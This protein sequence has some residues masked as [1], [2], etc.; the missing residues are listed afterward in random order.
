MLSYPICLTNALNKMYVLKIVSL[1][2]D[3]SFSKSKTKI[4][5]ESIVI[6]KNYKIGFVILKSIYIFKL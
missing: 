4:Q 3:K 2:D 5:I 1:L 6:S